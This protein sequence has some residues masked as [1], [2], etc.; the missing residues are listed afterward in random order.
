[1]AETVVHVTTIEEWKSVLDLLF[2]LGYSW[3]SEGKEYHR[4]YF[5]SGSRYLFLTNENRILKSQPNDGE[6]FIEYTD[7]MAQKKEGNKM[8]TYY[9]TQ[10]QLDLITELKNLPSPLVAI[11][12]KKY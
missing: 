10:E 8:E 1:M 2:R 5:N 4:E 9:V 6:P 3:N 7:F 11:M 12:N